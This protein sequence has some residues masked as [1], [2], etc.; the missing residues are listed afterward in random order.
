MG[1]PSVVGALL[2]VARQPGLAEFSREP[3]LTVACVM[4]IAVSV[5]WIVVSRLILREL[6]RAALAGSPRRRRRR[7]VWSEP[8]S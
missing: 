1:K 3:I 2:L 7:N 8:P 5:A 6:R 4:L